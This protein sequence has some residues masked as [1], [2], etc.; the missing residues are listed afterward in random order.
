MGSTE[1]PEPG[2]VW[3]L[4][5][6]VG[7]RP[8]AAPSKDPH[9]PPGPPS[10]VCEPEGPPTPLVP[11]SSLDPVSPQTRVSQDVSEC[12]PAGQPPT[13]C[14]SPRLLPAWGHRGVPSLQEAGAPS[15]VTHRPSLPESKAPPRGRPQGLAGLHLRCPQPLQTV[16]PAPTSTKRQQRGLA[17]LVT[18]RHGLPVEA[19]RARGGTG[20]AP[21]GLRVLTHSTGPQGHGAARG[22]A[23]ACDGVMTLDTQLYLKE[24][25][26]ELLMWSCARTRS[27][28]HTHS[29][30]RVCAQ[31]LRASVF[32]TAPFY[33]SHAASRV[34]VPSS[35]PSVQ[36]HRRA[37]ASTSRPGRPRGRS[38]FARGAGGLGLPG[39]PPR[40]RP[41]PP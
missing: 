10:G 35:R 18:G 29:G 39:A 19:G 30:A 21:C 37:P 24:K 11:Q 16:T 33:G 17:V 3:S 27:C 41:G 6:C 9:R 13:Q 4:R 1:R 2:P 23:V 26:T 34:T 7:T 12:S 22:H 40:G 5:L 32:A 38:A 31:A 25:V 14:H 15:S 36:S 28:V 20:V 8:A